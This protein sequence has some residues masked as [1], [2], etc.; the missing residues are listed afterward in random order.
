MI[1]V[2]QYMEIIDCR[3]TGGSEYLWRCYGENARYMDSDNDDC[4]VSII[5]DT[6]TQCVYEATV[7][8]YREDRAYRLFNPQFKDQM[9][10]ESLERNCPI[11]FAWDA[12]K[13][14]D[15]ETVDDFITKASAIVSGIDYDT[16]VCV[17]VDLADGEL[18]KLMMIAHE[19][20][21]TLNQLLEKI[22]VEE[23]AKHGSESP[24]IVANKKKK[25]KS[26]VKI[27]E[28]P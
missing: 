15:L 12:V 5:F 10:A 4:S 27:K 7:C 13:F 25:R 2:K 14:T 8:D 3:V 26:K 21:I 9:T 28:Q 20:D 19:Q 1:T 11:I 24:K 18:F 23:I 16:R 6:V 22:L 17:P